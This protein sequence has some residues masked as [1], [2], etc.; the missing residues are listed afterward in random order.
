MSKTTIKVI[1]FLVFLLALGVFSA[2]MIPINER[3]LSS[4]ATR[5]KATSATTTA[6][7]P[8]ESDPT[9][10]FTKEQLEMARSDPTGPITREELESA[11]KPL[12]KAYEDAS[13]GREADA[14]IRVGAW[15]TICRSS[16]QGFLVKTEG[17][18]TSLWES[19][20]RAERTETDDR[21]LRE[22]INRSINDLT[23]SGRALTIGCDDIVEITKQTG[24]V[25]TGRKI[26]VVV[27]SWQQTDPFAP[28]SLSRPIGTQ[29]WTLV[30][31]FVPARGGPSQDER[32]SDVAPAQRSDATR[33]QTPFD[34]KCLSY[35]PDLVTL[36]GTMTPKTFP[37]RP[38]YESIEKGDE[39]ETFWILDLAEPIC[40]NEGR[41]PFLNPA[42]QDV[43]NLQLLFRNAQLYRKR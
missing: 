30:D 33:A 5:S 28:R 31:F 6:S 29:G 13:R 3:I 40:T 22:V 35:A 38:N 26:Q 41:N 43:S 17:E 9:G 1:Q 18:L 2:V 24:D 10:H 14:G 4:L 20:V 39:P 8:S 16:N 36:T 15:G 19:I 32:A 12:I 7:T 21:V 37:G 23:S 25:D 42:E 34:A 27:V 11:R